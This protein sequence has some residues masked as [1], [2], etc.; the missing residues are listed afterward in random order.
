MTP[1]R[2]ILAA[3][4]LTSTFIAAQDKPDWPRIFVSENIEFTVYQPQIVAWTGALISAQAAVA[5]QSNGD[6]NV[7]YGTIAFK[8]KTD[9]DKVNQVVGL[10]D[11]AISQSVFPMAD[12]L[13]TTYAGLIQSAGSQWAQS[14]PLAPL[15]AAMLIGRTKRAD[16]A[17]PLDN[18]PPQ[19]V[20]TEDEDAVLVLIDGQPVLQDISGS[21]LQRVLNTNALIVYDASTSQSYLRVAGQWA[22]SGSLGGPWVVAQPPAAVKGLLA[23]AKEDVGFNFFERKPGSVATGLPSIFV[24]SSPAALVQLLGEPS[25]TPIP[26]TDILS[27]ANA[28]EPLFYEQSRKTYYLLLSG[29]WFS[30]PS[31][32]GGWQYVA[33]GALPGGFSNIPA[34]APQSK[35][36]SSVPGTAESQEALI[37]NNIPQTATVSRLQSTTVVYDG[38]PAFQK[39]EGSSLSYANNTANP[40]I[41]D[42]ESDYYVVTDG[43]WFHSHAALGPWMVADKVPSEIYALPPTS[44]LYYLTGVFVYGATE[45]DVYTGYTPTY[46]GTFVEDGV[47]VFGSGYSYNPYV[48]NVWFGAPLTYGFGVSVSL[49]EKHALSVSL[50]GHDWG[51]K[52]WWGPY[53]SIADD[54]SDYGRVD[55]YSAWTPKVASPVIIQSENNSDADAENQKAMADAVDANK[56]AA[57]AQQNNVYAGADG[58]VYRA[59]DSGNDWQYFDQGDWSGFTD[60]RLQADLAREQMARRPEIAR[61]AASSFRGG[62]GRR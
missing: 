52:P 61:R 60:T 39:I 23:R 3:T 14:I 46:L 1:F 56:V 26:G 2:L 6:T 37:A 59:G 25:M 10:S 44:P 30:T 12:S 48:G 15:Q 4:L 31:L 20:V 38:E 21:S 57:H 34:E 29:R 24:T 41:L 28:N 62:G 5:V 49:D 35:V 55:L 9:V 16:S 58:K 51:Q 33:S 18:T 27:V 32:S 53:G 22:Q 8:A 17:G 47:V 11:I 7:F 50:A 36:L 13:A 42:G 40:V 54:A 19:I 45:S 43:V